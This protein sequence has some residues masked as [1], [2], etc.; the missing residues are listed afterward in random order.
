MSS[1]VAASPTLP[2]RNCRNRS[3]IPASPAIVSCVP[4]NFG[5]IMNSDLF[6]S[7]PRGT[8]PKVDSTCFQQLQADGQVQGTQMQNGPHSQF[9]SP[10][11]Q[12]AQQLFLFSCSMIVSPFERIARRLMMLTCQSEKSYT[13]GKP[14]LLEDN[15]CD[16]APWSS[17]SLFHCQ[18][19]AGP[20][21]AGARPRPQTPQ[22]SLRWN[23]PTNTS[24]SKT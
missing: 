2:R 5:E 24:G 7:A 13:N 23:K 15:E 14:R 20:S 21:G 12:S 8:L 11:A 17:G 18:W 1:A 3:C 6:G 9:P 4:V 22:H 16:S 10:Q 19:P